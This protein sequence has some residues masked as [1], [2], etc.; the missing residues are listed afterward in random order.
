MISPNGDISRNGRNRFDGDCIARAE[1]LQF[2]T[3]LAF[4]V[5]E[6]RVKRHAILRGGTGRVEVPIVGDYRAFAFHQ[7]GRA[8]NRKTKYLAPAGGSRTRTCYQRRRFRNLGG[9]SRA[10]RNRGF[11]GQVERAGVRSGRDDVADN[12]GV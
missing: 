6:R 12:F 1:N 5:G 3:T 10:V 8:R 4:H 2:P 11:E 9:E 7:H